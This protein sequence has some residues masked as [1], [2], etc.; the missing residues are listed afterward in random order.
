MNLKYKENTNGF[1]KKDND[2]LFKFVKK[3]LNE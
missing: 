1:T 3:L 2:S